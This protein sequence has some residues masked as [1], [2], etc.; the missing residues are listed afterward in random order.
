MSTRTP[1]PAGQVTVAIRP[2]AGRKF[3]S[4]SSALM[5]TSIAAARI[6]TSACARLSGSPCAIRI[7]SRT[8]SIPVIISVIGCSTWISCVHLDKEKLAG[9]VINEI[10][11]C[12]G[13]AITDTFG[14]TYRRLAQ[15]LSRYVIDRRRGRL[16]PE[17]LTPPL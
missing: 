5:G 10:F 6:C 3:R 2:G 4:G 7:I 1:G 9:F 16:L 17:F 8:R 14:K 11:Q 12:S 15:H 13:P